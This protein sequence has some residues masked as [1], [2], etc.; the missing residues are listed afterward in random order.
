MTATDGGDAVKINVMETLEEMRKYFKDCAK[1]TQTGSA[2]YKRFNSYV[3]VLMLVIDQLKEDKNDYCVASGMDNP[4][5]R[6][7][8]R[9][10][11]R[12]GVREEGRR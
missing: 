12:A 9:D 5:E 7:G 3:F 10:A 2:A 11:D 6:V 8:R 1:N 4:A